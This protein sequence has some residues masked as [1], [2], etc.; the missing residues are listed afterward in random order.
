MT[1]AG[2][3]L[4]VP[5]GTGTPGDE[6]VAWGLALLA[7]DLCGDEV[8]LR[9]E[10]ARLLVEL[11]LARAAVEARL[12]TF[13]PSGRARLLW[14]A[15][16]EKR[17]LAPPGVPAVDRDALRKA[18]QLVRTT[19]A[20]ARAPVQGEAPLVTTPVPPQ[21]YP[22]FAVLTNPGTQW[23]GYNQVVEAAQRLLTPAGLAV[24]LAA[25]DAAAPLSPKELDTA[26]AG[27]GLRGPERWRNPPGFIYAGLNKGP[28]MRLRGAGAGSI[29]QAAKLDWMLVDRGDRS[30]LELALA[31]LGWFAVAR[32]RDTDAGR[33]VAVPAPV[34][35]RVPTVLDVLEATELSASGLP[36]F[37][38]SSAALAYSQ[39]ALLYLERLGTATAATASSV[40]RG[41]YL[42]RYWRPSGNTYAP[43]RVTLTPLPS[44]LPGLVGRE[45]LGAARTSLALHQRRLAAM[46]GRWAD[47]R[48][49][50]E[51]RRTAIGRYAQAVAGGARDWLR[52]V[53]SWYPAARAEERRLPAGQTGRIRAWEIDEVRRIAVT[54]EP[55][56][57]DILSHAAFRR[58][59]AAIRQAT[60][61]AHFA[62]QQRRPGFDPQYD[63][64][65]TLA[66]AADRHP[67]EFL[68]ELYEFAARYNDETMRRNEQ[69]PPAAR[70]AMLHGEDL[71]QVTA[72]VLDDR[73]GLVP[74]ALLAFGTSRSG[75]AA[76]AAREA[77]GVAAA[78][79]DRMPFD[80]E[81]GGDGP[82]DGDGES[83]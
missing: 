24:A 73:R 4:A 50:D 9:D 29:G 55:A 72:W 20:A 15:S 17:R 41:V 21:R 52:A 5:R 69:L 45:G 76:G 54:L 42:A 25:Y 12:G 36:A 7:S 58:V 48:R 75:R 27:L 11:P 61:V 65:E 77:E 14:L 70:R 51:E 68:R 33:V 57:E 30:L 6:L 46:R 28:T 13:Q 40:L 67:R 22:L 10:G 26:L 60:V 8:D 39:A 53:A 47:E 49:L 37:T 19:A 59:S 74:A 34:H 63:L 35:V 3:R 62:R 32:V 44:W 81:P 18:A 78:D 64:I 1:E 38:S 79:E 23:A 43:D 83:E 82:D 31:Y 66:G 80:E 56:L 71:E 2:L 16:T